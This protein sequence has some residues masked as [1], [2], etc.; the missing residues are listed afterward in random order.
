MSLANRVFEASELNARKKEVRLLLDERTYRPE[1][2]CE[3]ERVGAQEYF[4][5]FFDVQKEL[6]SDQNNESMD[7]HA[8]PEGYHWEEKVM[9]RT[10]T[11]EE[12]T[13]ETKRKCDEIDEIRDETV[14]EMKK[15][16]EHR[17]FVF[18]NL[19]KFYNE[20]VMKFEQKW[21]EFIDGVDFKSDS[22]VESEKKRGEEK[23]EKREEEKKDER[24]RKSDENIGV[25]VID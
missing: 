21:L 25:I 6:N 1:D 8:W 7:Q 20:R 3:E 11:R 13:D 23:E 18:G 17:K 24:K 2:L 12:E 22:W 5:S 14:K 4:E 15:S 19:E 9:V 16:D 10:K